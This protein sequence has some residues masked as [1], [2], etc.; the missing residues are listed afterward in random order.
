MNPSQKTR[1]TGL[2]VAGAQG[3]CEALVLSLQAVLRAYGRD[4]EYDEL[5][6]V[7]GAAFMSTWAPDV[8]DPSWW[9]VFGRDAFLKVSA[10]AYGLSLRELHP[11]EAVPRPVAPREFDQHFH[12]SYL[13][14]IKAALDRDEPALAWMGW[15]APHEMLWGVITDIDPTSGR[16]IGRSCAQP[17]DRVTLSGTPVHVYIVQ[18]YAE[19]E[20]RPV[21]LL[22]AAMDRAALVLNNRLDP[23]YGVTSGPAALEQ[24]RD[25]FDA[26]TGPGAPAARPGW[27]GAPHVY[28]ARLARYTV[29]NRRTAL[30]FFARFRNHADTAQA[31][32]IDECAAAFREIIACMEPACDPDQVRTLLES[33]KGRRDLIDAL[34]RAIGF[35]RRAANITTR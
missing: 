33:D 24:W 26:D 18:E 15:P 6:A 2:R 35:E 16:C 3:Q 5:A 7:T 13:P 17:D 32:R 20:P 25:T 4:V 14:F 27:D 10:Q 34:T 28:H 29:C 23:G 12:D 11:P 9:P 21:D 31:E 30:R 1:L 19:T 8:P 22:D